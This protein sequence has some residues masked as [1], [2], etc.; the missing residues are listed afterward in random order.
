MPRQPKR[1]LEEIIQSETANG[2]PAPEPEPGPETKT[3][4]YPSREG[5]VPVQFFLEKDAHRQL[6]IV[7]AE[8]DKSHQDILIEAL[9]AWFVVNDL[10]PIA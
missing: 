6:K 3:R 10:P 4:S 8:T 5:K 7:S 2:F 9:N 1:G